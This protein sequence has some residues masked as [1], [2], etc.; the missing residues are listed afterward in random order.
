MIASAKADFPN[1]EKYFTQARDLHPDRSEP[2]YYLGQVALE[3]GREADAQAMFGQCLEK[4]SENEYAAM[5]LVEIQLRQGTW[6]LARERLQKIRD[7]PNSRLVNIA[8]NALCLVD[9]MLGNREKATECINQNSE[10]V[11][12]LSPD[13]QT[14]VYSNKAILA[15]RENNKQE[16]IAQARKV[17]EI[18]PS[19]PDAFYNLGTFQMEAGNYQDAIL[20]Y[21]RVLD[22]NA[23]HAEALYN[24]GVAE[25]HQ[26]RWE[27]VIRIL[28]DLA[29]AKPDDVNIARELA[30]A[31]IGAGK[32]QEAIDLLNP[33]LERRSSDVNLL[34]LKIKAM[35]AKGD[36]EEARK[37]S[38][39]AIKNFPQD[40]QVHH[41]R[42]IVT[43]SL[44][45][46]NS[47]GIHFQRAVQLLPGDL[48]VLINYA[49]YLIRLGDFEKSREAELLLQ[50]IDASGLYP[51]AVI[52]QKAMLAIRRTD[53]Q[54]ARS[55]LDQSLQVNNNQP[56]IEQLLGQ[57]NAF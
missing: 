26:G 41:I 33:V 11:Q 34:I 24:L 22:L 50:Q 15:S 44:G 51:T 23:E 13:L 37:L 53:F 9:L 35:L 16:S 12:D 17:A 45:D 6:D 20:A 21:R 57:I 55:L 19:N 47:A 7:N 29:Q 10:Q 56:E 25:A 43:C 46:L 28:A 8:A 14:A 38:E 40:G 5:A 31:Y 48:S 27:E 52:N 2:Y 32:S 3:Q 18:S 49:T 30:Q 1:A 54:T 4:N 39:E 42:G 36:N